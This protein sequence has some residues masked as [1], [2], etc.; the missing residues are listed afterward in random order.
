MARGSRSEDIWV[1]TEMDSGFR[2]QEA[3]AV[4]GLSLRPEGRGTNG[5]SRFL[6]ESGR[7]G[8]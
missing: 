7:G 3:R 8:G 4:F 5:R 1:C 6:C 2:G